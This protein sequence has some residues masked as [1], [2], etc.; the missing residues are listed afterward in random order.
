MEIRA[1]DYVRW[2]EDPANR[3]FDVF[4]AGDGISANALATLKERGLIGGFVRT[5]HH[6][7]AFADPRLQALQTRALV[8]PDRHFVVSRLWQRLLADEFGI[9]AALVGNGVDMRRYRSSPSPEDALV[10]ARHG[11]VGPGPLLLA[12]GGVEERKNTLRILDAFIRVRA[13]H[14]TARLAI[15]G[16][17]SL[18]DHDAYHAAFAE[19]L[20]RSGLPAGAVVRLGP[21]PDADM[22]SLYR[23]ADALLFP[24]VKE[25]FG[26]VVL[27]AMASACPVVL[28]R[29][30][31]FTEYCGEQDVAWCDRRIP[32]P[33]PP[34]RPSRSTATVPPGSPPWAAYR[35]RPRLDRRRARPPTHLCRRR[36]GR[37][38]LRCASPSAGP[39]AGRRPA[40]RRPSS[41]ATIWPSARPIR[42]R[43]SSPAAAPPS[44]SPASV[45]ARN[46]AFPV[47]EPSA[48]S[49]SSR[50][51]PPLRVRPGRN[52]L[53]PFLRGFTA[54]TAATPRHVSVA[55]IG[56]GQ[57]GFP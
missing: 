41:S 22:P 31:P 49:P 12:V 28:S 19:R 4:H 51:P 33:S 38:C 24:S 36:G 20:A 44:A 27:E 30:A 9:A 57:A 48:S 17:A 14:P 7:D 10:R 40:T 8:T 3:R 53:H 46:T 54:M 6:V 21:V 37:P 1:A 42:S 50:T 32:P 25:G 23:V 13:I 35:R 5:V 2:F 16:G 29:I 55:V 43:I 11:L 34:P 45:C 26:L 15:A 56:G 52:R 39:T 47:P 18:L